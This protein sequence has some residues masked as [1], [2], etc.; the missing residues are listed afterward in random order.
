[1]SVLAVTRENGSQP[2]RGR[3]VGARAVRTVA[4]VVSFALVT[5]VVPAVVL[6]PTVA[7]AATTA[8]KKVTERPDDYSAMVAARSQG[9]PV[10]ITSS[11]TPTTVTFANPDGSLTQNPHSGIAFTMARQSVQSRSPGPGP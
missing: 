10:A 6:T 3:G 5:A 9:T 1:M 7:S 8:A 11:R 2:G 4:T